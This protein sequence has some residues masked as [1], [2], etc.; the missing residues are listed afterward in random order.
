MDAGE[1]ADVAALRELK[2]ETGF[3]GVIIGIG[4]NVALDPGIS[5]STMKIVTVK[6][7]LLCKNNFLLELLT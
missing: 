4:R 7:C 1:T 5:N 2:E 6:V 3:S